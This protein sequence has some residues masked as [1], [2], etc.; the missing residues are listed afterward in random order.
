MYDICSMF[1]YTAAMVYLQPELVKQD[2]GR[3]FFMFSFTSMSEQKWQEWHL[4]M[5]AMWAQC[6]Q[7]IG[8][9]PG[10]NITCP[11]YSNI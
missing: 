8:L 7:G 1:S 9:Y 4:S 5:C 11:I 3:Y 6:N 2:A 10:H